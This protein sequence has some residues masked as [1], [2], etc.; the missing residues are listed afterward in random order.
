MRADAA[1]ARVVVIGDALIDELVDETGTSRIVGG[2]GLNV[3]VG[4]RIL[5]MPTTLIAMIGDDADGE[6]V[7]R[8]LARYDV[9]L[10]PTITPRG[11]G[12]ARS[13]RLGGEPHYSFSEPMLHRAIDFDAGQRA[14]I[15][16]ARVVAISGFPFDDAAQVELLAG[17]LAETGA[18]AAIDPNPRSGML[19]DAA[20]FVASLE[21]VAE[22]SGLLKLGDE[23]ARLLYSQS[24]A[25]VAARLLG[26]IERVLVTEGGAGATMHVGAWSAHRAALA[27]PSAVVDTMGGGDSVFATVLAEVAVHG[28]AEV[29]WELALGRAM[30]VAAATVTHPGALLRMPSSSGTGVSRPA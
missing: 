15:R 25:E 5:G 20:A 12:I 21:R 29:D 3:A 17:A 30:E 23:D 22:V 10:I 26:S 16:D 19:H 28:L 13:E 8:H 2:S 24:V 1:G 27:E 18:V 14:A 6:L 9:E 11:T 4:L 7:R